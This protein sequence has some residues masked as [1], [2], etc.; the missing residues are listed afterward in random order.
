MLWFRDN[1]GSLIIL[2]AVV[3]IAAFVIAGIVKAKKKGKASCG[4]GGKCGECSGCAMSGLCNNK[5][6]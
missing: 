1:I 3:A 6:N 5:K 4:C 2:F